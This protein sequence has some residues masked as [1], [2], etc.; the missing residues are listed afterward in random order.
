[1]ICKT[2]AGDTIGISIDPY[3]IQVMKRSEYS[4]TFGDYSTF[5]DEMDNQL[6]RAIEELYNRNK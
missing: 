3:E 6:C 5:S 2:N 4:D 1:M